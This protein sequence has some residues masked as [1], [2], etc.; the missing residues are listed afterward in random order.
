[1]KF[2]NIFYKKSKNNELE[3]IIF[4]K[5]GFSFFALLFGPLWFLFHKMW[6]E[7]LALLVVGV[8]LALLKQISFFSSF[9][10]YLMQLALA[11]AIA[12]NSNHWRAEYL[13]KKK[14]H[15]L[16]G[17]IIAKNT[18]EARLKFVDIFANKV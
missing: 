2:Y 17:F 5:E 11:F 15:R 8:V 1:M 4:I 7:F 9:D 6:R 13:H 10:L 3:N 18:D 12:I 14:N 16:L